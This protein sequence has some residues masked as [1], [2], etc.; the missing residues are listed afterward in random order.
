MLEL[1]KK[2][3]IAN[4]VAGAVMLI[5]AAYAAYSGDTSMLKELALI[6]AGYLFGRTTQRNN[7]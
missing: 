2:T 4:V 1:L 3:T 5:A 7:Q 6:G